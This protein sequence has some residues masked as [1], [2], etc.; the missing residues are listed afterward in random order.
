MTGNHAQLRAQLVQ[1]RK[2]LRLTQE[3]V[4]RIM[5]T[6]QTQVSRVVEHGD[7]SISTLECYVEALGGR[8]EVCAVAGDRWPVDRLPSQTRIPRPPL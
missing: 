7:P 2:Y 6:S 5:Y 1:V 4:A 3:D 8:L